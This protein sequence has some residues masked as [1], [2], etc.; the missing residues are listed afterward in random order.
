MKIT[1]EQERL[2]RMLLVVNHAV[3][4]GAGAFPMATNIRITAQD[5]RIRLDATNLNIGITAWVEA[6]VLEA[7]EVAVPAKLFT[8]LI[9]ALSSGII[10]IVV[11][12]AY[13]VRVNGARGPVH[14]RGVDPEQFPRMPDVE[15]DSNPT[16]L[17]AALL[18]EVIKEVSIAVDET[19]TR[20]VFGNILVQIEPQLIT[21]A[22]ADGYG[23]L[24]FRTLPLPAES[25]LTCDI[26][27]PARSL[28]KLANI[29]PTEGNVEIRLTSSQVI[30]STQWM[31]L[32][33]IL[34][35]GNY[36]NYKATLPQQ[37]QTTVTVKTADLREIVA[38]TSL[39]AKSDYDA[40]RITIKASPGVEPGKLTITAEAAD[41]GGNCTT[42]PAAVV[43]E[44]QDELIFNMATLSKVL[45]VI[46]AP[47]LTF[48]VGMTK[49]PVGVMRA[50]GSYT[51][52]HTLMSMGAAH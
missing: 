19:G 33:S 43:G 16:I 17:K 37:T 40:G 36:P 49:A 29:L 13:D 46:P 50:K 24:A 41:V 35:S 15:Q 38:L 32:S 44:D 30:F 10:E 18:K 9:G 6:T 22:A 52:T 28:A 7:G 3:A 8:D 20:E 11:D 25:K 42:I 23:K 34:A 51:C 4:Q 39:F 21:F 27:I 12:N 45:S 26:L 1:C 14:V 2:N 47:E 48:E 31:L 5:T